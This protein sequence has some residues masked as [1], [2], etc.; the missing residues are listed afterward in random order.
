MFDETYS[1]RIEERVFI[2]KAR[3]EIVLNTQISESTP[4]LSMRSIVAALLTIALLTGGVVSWFASN[5]NSLS[6]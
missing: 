2:Y 4:G 6:S 3:P 1:A 5:S